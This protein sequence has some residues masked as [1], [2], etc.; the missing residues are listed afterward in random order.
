VVAVE[1]DNIIVDR[2]IRLR[3]DS[4]FEVEITG[5]ELLPRMSWRMGIRMDL[6]AR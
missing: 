4:T 6:M 2:N 5:I 3:Q 1:G